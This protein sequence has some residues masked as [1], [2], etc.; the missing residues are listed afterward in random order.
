MKALEY[1][2]TQKDVTQAVRDLW[3]SEQFLR[4]HD[5]E[6]G[7][8][9][10]V[11]KEFARFPR[12]FCTLTDSSIERSHFLTWMGVLPR[13]SEYENDAISDLYYFHE[14]AHLATMPYA[15]DLP[16]ERFAQKMADNEMTASLMSEVYVYFAMPELRALTF[17]FEIWADAYL[18][19]EELHA[20][21][22]DDY[23]AFEDYFE[24]ERLRAMHS[25]K[26]G[27]KSEALIAKYAT[28]NEQWASTWRENYN[29]V[30]TR[31]VA[32]KEC[33]RTMK[34]KA[35]NELGAWLLSKQGDALTP[36]EKEARVFSEYV[37]AL[38]S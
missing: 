19:Q 8:V 15:R 18:A 35:V 33:A 11:V 29:E 23:S 20:L 26:E 32:F 1:Y 6:G 36:Y 22:K 3:R 7:F 25:P 37:K 13:R 38:Y 14:I 16:F 10:R 12:L 9:Q 34:G 5:E 2:E 28:L 4:S 30:E 27:D 17:D 24:S 31:M 21:A